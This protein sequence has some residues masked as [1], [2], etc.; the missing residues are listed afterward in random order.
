MSRLHDGAQEAADAA[1]KDDA[2]T[3]K[4][5]EI[6]FAQ[7]KESGV[8]FVHSDAGVPYALI[9]VIGKDASQVFP[10]RS[11][12]FRVYLSYLYHK[13]NGKAPSRAIV[14]DALAVMEGDALFDGAEVEVHVRDRAD[15]KSID[16][17]LGDNDYQMVHVSSEGWSV[18]PHA[19]VYFLR[20]AA[21]LPMPKPSSDGTGLDALRPFINA[22][23]ENF[24][25]VLI[26]AICAMRG[27][28]PFPILVL[29]GEQ[30]SAKTT[31]GKFLKALIDPG[32]LDA[33][34]P[35][36]DTHDLAIAADS[37]YMLMFDNISDM[38]PGMADAF[39]RI[40]TGGS[41]TTRTLYTDRDEEI[42]EGQ[43]PQVFTSIEDL[44]ARPD[45]ADRMLPAQLIAIPDDERK[46][47]EQLWSDFRKVQAQ[48]LG[49]LLDVLVIALQ[50]IETVRANAKRLPRMAD[51]Y[52]WSL[53]A[54]AALPTHN[55]VTV[56]SVWRRTREE[57]VASALEASIIAAPLLQLLARNIP[58][59]GTAWE[60]TASE[61]LRQLNAGADDQLRMQRAWPV[62]GRSLMTKLKRIGPALRAKGFTFAPSNRTAKA[63]TWC[64]SHVVDNTPPPRHD[65]AAQPSS[66]SSSSQPHPSDDGRDAND[67]SPRTLGSQ[68]NGAVND[69]ELTYARIRRLLGEPESGDD[70]LIERAER[71]D[72]I[73]AADPIVQG[74]L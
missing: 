59:P 52:L 7:A 26:F 66:A 65:T 44:M 58:Q 54:E 12:R 22:D 73:I 53:A 38:S 37:S 8:N 3:Q 30:G 51:A 50:K 41:F 5:A 33:R 45:L 43:R 46:S 39:C 13:Q 29:H 69:R 4:Q 28:G 19:D 20:P 63:R 32:K 68:S 11:N 1:R 2:K 10:I 16:I 40:S 21:M 31:A 15:D 70:E 36:R 24:L 61:V 35:C 25:R 14:T 72:E 71:N 74:E 42:F 17:D 62:N 18:Q 56:E 27:R 34:A 9:P 64:F 23:D 47:E 67:D 57:A 49:A 6:L 48:L 60:A 55:G